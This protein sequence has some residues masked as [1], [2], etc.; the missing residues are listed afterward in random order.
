MIGIQVQD[1]IMLILDL[2]NI[3]SVQ[4]TQE[5]KISRSNAIQ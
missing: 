5:V 4:S 2:K 3:K 1:S